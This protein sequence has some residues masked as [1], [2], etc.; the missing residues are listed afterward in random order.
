MFGFKNTFLLSSS[1]PSG[2][3]TLFAKYMPKPQVTYPNVGEKKD[4]KSVV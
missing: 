2:P 4:R 3:E 1:S